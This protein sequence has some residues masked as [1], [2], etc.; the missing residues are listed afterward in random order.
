MENASEGYRRASMVRP[1]F[2]GR[3]TELVSLLQ[4]GR[5]MLQI[6]CGVRVCDFRWLSEQFDNQ[7]RRYICIDSAAN[8]LFCVGNHIPILINCTVDQGKTN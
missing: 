1:V 6:I 7:I 2:D 3:I 5:R 8:P 4:Y